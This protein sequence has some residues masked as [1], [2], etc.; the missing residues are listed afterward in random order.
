MSRRPLGSFL[1]PSCGVTILSIFCGLGACLL[2]A[3][4]RAELAICGLMLAGLFD[5][6]DGP[7]GRLLGMDETQ[8][9]FRTQLDMVADMANFGLAP[10]VILFHC[11]GFTSGVEIALLALFELAVA[12]RLA[13]FGTFGFEMKE[14]SKRYTGLPCTFVALFLPVAY[15]ATIPAVAIRETVLLVLV[16]ILTVAMVSPVRIPKPAGIW[17]LIFPLCAAGLTVLFVYR[18]FAG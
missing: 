14:D 4:G 3:T 17:L 12:L 5:F 7:V 6:L 2:A 15:A 1:A 13:F 18:A 11:G 9:R 16:P 8:I 10:A